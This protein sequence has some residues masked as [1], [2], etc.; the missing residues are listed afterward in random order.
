MLIAALAK[1]CAEEKN[2]QGLPNISTRL[3]SSSNEWVV[4]GDFLAWYASQ[5]VSAIWADVVTVGL[6]T[7]SWEAVGFNFTWDYGFRIGAGYN[8]AY[9]QWDS[10]FYWTW[11][12]TDDTHSIPFNTDAEIIPEL[13]AAFLSGDTPRSMS[14]KWT[15][16]LNMF[17][18]ELGRSYWISKNLA[19]RPFLGI[20]GGWINQLI[21]GQYFNLIINNIPTSN[22]GTERLKNNFWGAG[23]TGGINT[24]WRVGDFGFHCIDFFGDFSIA[25]MWGS[26][27]CKDFYKNTAGQTSSVN[28]K[29][30]ALGSLMFRGFL[31]L[32][33]DLNFSSN[34]SRF[35]TRLGYE[36]Q[37]WLN[38]L[39]FATFQLQR[40][41]GD[42][43][44]QGVTFNCRFDF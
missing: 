17:D 30:A 35:S 8:L 15:F 13:Y 42:L 16:F 11:F 28:M 1:L 25:T 32:E 18:W 37:L 19:L 9:D 22:S 3:Q 26:W 34:K 2:V 21:H 5:E 39:R 41:H 31:G 6:N 10:I 38:Q 36:M 12:K 44:L 7:S 20:K 27:L 43:T 23:P 24:K 4:S 29:K 33:W 14:V 40:L